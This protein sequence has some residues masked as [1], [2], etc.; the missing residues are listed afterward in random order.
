MSGILSGT[1]VAATAV[2]AAALRVYF[3]DDQGGIREG[4]YPTPGSPSG[5]GVSKT[6]IF[7]AKL[8]T[9]LA[10][11]SWNNGQQV[12]HKP[13]TTNHQIRIYC[14]SNNNTLQ[15]WAYQGSSWAP[16]YLSSSNFPASS[17]SSLSAV[18]W[19]QNGGAQIRLYAQG[20]ITQ[21]NM[22]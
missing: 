9:P 15:E 1:A 12:W 6:P 11:I 3:Q 22:V 18:Y 13:A 20:N 14:L 17:I 7:T 4:T 16:G 2:S 8:Y 19:T 10:V 21:F 5:W